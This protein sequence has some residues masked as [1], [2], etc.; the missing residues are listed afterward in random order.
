MGEIEGE[1]VRDDRSGDATT[2]VDK[3]RAD[4]MHING[5]RMFRRDIGPGISSLA[6]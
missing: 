2:A 6:C 4:A 5:F 3:T 1:F